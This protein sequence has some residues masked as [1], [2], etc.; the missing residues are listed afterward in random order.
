[1]SNIT[2]ELIDMALCNIDEKFV[3]EMLFAPRLDKQALRRVMG[4]ALPVAAA[5]AVFAVC[6]G[7][8]RAKLPASAGHQLLKHIPT[9]LNI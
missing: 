5:A 4:I 8:S 3:Q 6:F 9:D 7:V 2:N 1:M